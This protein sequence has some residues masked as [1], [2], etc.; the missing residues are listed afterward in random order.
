MLAWAV[1]PIEH[2]LDIAVDQIGRTCAWP[3]LTGARGGKRELE[4]RGEAVAIRDEIAGTVCAEHSAT[5]VGARDVE[6][7]GSAAGNAAGCV[8]VLGSK[9]QPAGRVAT[10]RSGRRGSARGGSSPRCVSGRP[11]RRRRRRRRPRPRAAVRLGTA[12]CRGRSRAQLRSGTSPRRR[13]PRARSAAG[14]SG[15]LHGGVL[16]PERLAG[17]GRSVDEHRAT[18]AQLG[19]EV[20]PRDGPVVAVD[21]R[22][23]QRWELTVR[24]QEASAVGVDLCDW[25]AGQDPQASRPPRDTR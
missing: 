24:V 3:Q 1:T 25:P 4:C 21:R 13:R 22:G 11:G 14:R 10:R 16:R 17:P 19:F 15:E 5:L 18:S 23:Y 8:R 6:L 20:R 2:P 12:R 7:H 9:Q